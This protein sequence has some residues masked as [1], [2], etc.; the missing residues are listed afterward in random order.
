MLSIIS[1]RARFCER[2]V[3]FEIAALFPSLHGKGKSAVIS[4]L[5]SFTEKSPLLYCLSSSTKKLVVKTCNV[6]ACVLVHLVFFSTYLLFR[7]AIS[8]VRNKVGM[9]IVL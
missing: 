1:P 8:S 2:Y 6:L 5:T 3:Y 4:K 7:N 9:V